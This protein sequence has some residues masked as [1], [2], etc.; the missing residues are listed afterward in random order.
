MSTGTTSNEHSGALDCYLSDSVDAWVAENAERD[1][2]EL[3]FEKH[4]NADRI[5][6]RIKRAASLL[7]SAIR[8]VRQRFPDANYYSANEGFELLLGSSHADGNNEQP[9]QQRIVFIG[10]ANVDALSGGDW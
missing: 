5:A 10:H 7:N 1:A 3:F 4:P 9:Q 2:T 8:E 6:A